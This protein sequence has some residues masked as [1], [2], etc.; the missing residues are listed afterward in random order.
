MALA[1]EAR[2]GVV[3]TT[4]SLA[5]AGSHS[6]AS[7]RQLIS[8][9]VFSLIIQRL[10]RSMVNSAISELVRPMRTQQELKLQPDRMGIAE[11][12]ALVVI[13]LEPNLGELAGV[14]RQG[15]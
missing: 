4:F 9:L 12:E 15:R 3:A 10:H 5:H 13:V 6:T 2:S 1:M 7:I 8:N 14:K 11:Q